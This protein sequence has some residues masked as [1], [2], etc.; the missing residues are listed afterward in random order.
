VTTLLAL[1]GLCLA[2]VTIRYL[3]RCAVAPWGSCARCRGRRRTCR[4]CDGTGLRPRL[5]WQAYAR[6]RRTWKD[7]TR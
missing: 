6:L 4:K 2:I 5:T 3:I 7:G 1:L